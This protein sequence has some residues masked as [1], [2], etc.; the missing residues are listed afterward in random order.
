MDYK[1]KI[2]ELPGSPGVYIMKD[3]KGAVL[4]V[5]K[6]L[7]IRRR[8]STYFYPHRYLSERMRA[9]TGKVADIS[10]IHTVTEAEALIYENSLIKQLSPRYNVALRDDKSYPMLKLSVNEK[11]PRIFI[12]RQRKN[13]GALYYGPYANAKL[14]REALV[15]LRQIFPLRSCNKMPKG[16]CL[17]YHIMQCAAPCVGK[18]NEGVYGEII[19]EL[20]L[21][22]EGKTAELLKIL[23]EKMLEASA[24]EDFEKAAR[25]KRRIESIDAV[26]KDTVRYGPAGEIEELKHILEIKGALDVIE[27]FDVSDIMGKDAVGSMIYFYKGKPKKSEYRKFRIKT[28]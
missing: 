11:F 9:M 4:Y 8:V 17:N 13:D 10:Y 19:D 28:V 22:L 18:I 23:S 2:K 1:K 20:K 26:K 24:K 27:A 5:G 3:A 14:L 6:A 12:T 25:I 15:I 7:N 16:V 21:F